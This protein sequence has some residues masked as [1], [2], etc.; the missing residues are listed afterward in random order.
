[1]LTTNIIIDYIIIHELT[2]TII[3]NHS[4]K[5]YNLVAKIMPNYKLAERWL[6]QNRAIIDLI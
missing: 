3:K 1:M 2:N 6:K 5:F 4:K